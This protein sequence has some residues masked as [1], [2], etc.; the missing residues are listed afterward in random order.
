MAQCTSVI[1]YST[2]DQIQ[3]ISKLLP[4]YSW[5]CGWRNAEAYYLLGDSIKRGSD[6][7]S[8]PFNTLLMEPLVIY[9]NTLVEVGMQSTFI[10]KTQL[11]VW[12]M[13]GL[14]LKSHEYDYPKFSGNHIVNNS[15]R[16]PIFMGDKLTGPLG[17]VSR[18]LGTLPI[19]L[20]NHG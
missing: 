14:M 2:Q 13:A 10:R 3:L 12:L 5:R 19:A 8:E 18:I 1:K 7:C 4:K 20:V 16:Y 9:G 15:V 6:C 17:S 11:T